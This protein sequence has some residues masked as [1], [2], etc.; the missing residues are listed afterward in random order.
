MSLEARKTDS[1][2]YMQLHTQFI[3]HSEEIAGT[4]RDLYRH[5]E[6]DGPGVQKGW[7]RFVKQVNSQCAHQFNLRCSLAQNA[8][9]VSNRVDEAS[10]SISLPSCCT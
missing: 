2:C 3:Q 6:A 1:L 5:F 8:M 7:Q 10:Q 9:M 4:V